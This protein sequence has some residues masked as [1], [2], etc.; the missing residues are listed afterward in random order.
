MAEMDRQ[1][2]ENPPQNR[3]LNVEQPSSY[4]LRRGSAVGSEE[5]SSGGRRPSVSP[6]GGESAPHSRA[7]DRLRAMTDAKRQL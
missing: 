3:H 2:G 6:V 7:S 1:Y 5:S 4:R